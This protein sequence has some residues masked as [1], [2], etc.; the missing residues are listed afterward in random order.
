MQ[1]Y[2]HKEKVLQIKANN[3]FDKLKYNI[4]IRCL[5]EL[6]PLSIIQPRRL[7]R[8]GQFPGLLRMDRMVQRCREQ[9][10]RRFSAYYVTLVL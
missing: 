3:K 5:I 2:F 7:P 6:L 8:L 10:A 9:G 4:F 1:H